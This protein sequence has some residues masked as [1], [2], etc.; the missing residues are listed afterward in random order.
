[1]YFLLFHPIQYVSYPLRELSKSQK[2]QVCYYGGKASFQIEK[3]L[4]QEIKRDIPLLDGY[5]SAFLKNSS[6]AK[7]L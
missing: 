1:M 4:V 3:G 6:N 7:S 2:R 5:N